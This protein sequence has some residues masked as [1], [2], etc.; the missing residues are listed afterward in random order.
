MI[1]SPDYK[2][3]KR[4]NFTGDTFTLPDVRSSI[5]RTIEGYHSHTNTDDSK[6]LE[7]EP[8]NVEIRTQ[9]T[10]R[11]LTVYDRA[12]F[13]LPYADTVI[14]TGRDPYT[15]GLCYTGRVFKKSNLYPIIE[16][17][18]H[19]I[20]YSYATKYYNLTSM[21]IPGY[22]CSNIYIDV[23]KGALMNKWIQRWT[24]MD[25][26]EM[27]AWRGLPSWAFSWVFGE[28]LK[29]KSNSASLKKQSDFLRVKHAN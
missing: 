10:D 8:Q 11:I 14:I 26:Q 21:N 18:P 28:F 19:P 7:K 6:R 2:C 1:L 22:Q 5:I 27:E 12:L 15:D 29:F 17:V 3:F 4:I 9:N 13:T 16:M 24:H 20:Y 23:E 25:T